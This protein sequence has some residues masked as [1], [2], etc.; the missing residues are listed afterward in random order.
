MALTEEASASAMTADRMPA[1]GDTDEP[2]GRSARDLYNPGKLSRGDGCEDH[3]VQPD[4]QDHHDDRS[5]HQR[6][7][8]CSRRISHLSGDVHRTVPSAVSE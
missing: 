6:D 8:Q 7:G 5:G 2:D 4:V 1:T 3:K